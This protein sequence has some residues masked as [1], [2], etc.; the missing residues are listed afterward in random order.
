VKVVNYVLH[1]ALLPA[2][3]IVGDNLIL[4]H[5]ALG[6]VIHPQVTM[7][8]DC[9]IYHNVTLASESGIGSPFRIVLGDGVTIGAHSIIVARPNCSLIIGDGAIV[10]AGSVV[11]RDIPSGEV[12]AGNPARKLRNR[13][14]ETSDETS[15]P[16]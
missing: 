11:T 13:G 5:Y 3:A 6:V 10:G 4:E 8:E 9:R 12:W 16:A 7:G 14:T 15:S 1:K 2:E